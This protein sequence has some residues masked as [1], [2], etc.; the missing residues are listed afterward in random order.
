MPVK[1]LVDDCPLYDLEP[2]EPD[3]WIYGNAEPAKP[4]P[5]GTRRR[6]C[7]APR[8]PDDRLQALGLRAVRLARAVAHGAPPRAGRR[9]GA[10]A[11]RDR[12][13]DR[14]L[15]R[16]QRAPRRLRPLRGH[17]RGGARVR[18][19][20]RLRRRRAAR[21]DQLPQL[22]QPGE[23][24]RRLAARPLDPGARRRLHRARRPG[25][26]RQRLPLQRDRPGPDLPDAGRRH[27]RRAAVA[28]GPAGDARC[29]AGD[30]IAIAGPFAPSLAGSELAKMRGELGAG[31]G[32]FDV[33]EVRAAIVEVREAVRG[34][35]PA[36]DSRHQRR[37]SRLRARRDRDRRRL[38]PPGRSRSADGPRAATPE[39]W[40]FG[41]GP[42]GFVVAG[43][44]GEI[45][46]LVEAGTAV[47]IGVAS[48]DS[49]RIAA[50]DADGRADRRRRRERPGARW[51]P[52]ASKPRDDVASLRLQVESCVV[53]IRRRTRKAF[54]P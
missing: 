31:L 29:A 21:P 51:A 39:D 45:E 53:L 9:R 4:P 49:I 28:R 24:D 34:R 47:L 13:G 5:P 23:A 48:G 12:H 38:R 52:S 32:A 7:R 16:R 20:P 11:R 19:E 37:R 22:R 35:A 54:P 43:E 2:A 10:P 40:L 14:R 30:A 46:K 41:E 1:L 42:G 18:A 36:H 33:G 3:D 44:V 26:R 27:G 50:G 6:R 15:D 8:R 25:R 17:D